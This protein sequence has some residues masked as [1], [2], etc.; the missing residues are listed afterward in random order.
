MVR[1]NSFLHLTHPY[2]FSSSCNNTLEYFKCGTNSVVKEIV[3]QMNRSGAAIT[4]KHRGRGWRT[5]PGGGGGTEAPAEGD[6]KELL[7]VG[8]E[9]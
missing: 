7:G 3:G 1:K 4:C 9:T 6:D 2:C 8:E 5:P